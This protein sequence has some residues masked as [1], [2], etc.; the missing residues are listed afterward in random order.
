MVLPS[1]VDDDNEQ[2]GIPMSLVEAMARGLPVVS[3]LTGG[4]PELLGAGAGVLVPPG[5]PVALANAIE[6]IAT[7]PE[8]HCKLAIE[9]KGRANQ[10]FSVE[11]TVREFVRRLT[12]EPPL[13][14]KGVAGY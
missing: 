10:G 8:L 5:D 12:M 7:H 4:I 1:I 11:R 13:S 2:E 3:T 6:A 14:E 9:G